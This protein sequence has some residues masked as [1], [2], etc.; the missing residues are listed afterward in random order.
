MG[1]VALLFFFWI[2]DSGLAGINAFAFFGN[3]MMPAATLPPAGHKAGVTQTFKY[4]RFGA[5]KKRG[6]FLKIGCV[7]KGHCW[8]GPREEDRMV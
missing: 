7:Q 3:A 2:Y 4:S 6:A 1:S 8:R 5:N